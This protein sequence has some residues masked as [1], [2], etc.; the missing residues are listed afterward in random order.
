MNIAIAI[1]RY[2]PLASGIERS[3]E[4]MARD[5]ISRGHRVTVI[6]G[7]APPDMTLDGGEILC[8]H[9]VDFRH[10]I[11]VAR[12]ARW[13]PQ[14]LA[15][16]QA[17]ITLSM[18]LACPAILVQ[19]R[20]GILAERLKREAVAM[21]FASPKSKRAPMHWLNLPRQAGLRRERATAANPM[22]RRFIAISEYVKQQLIHHHQIAPDRIDLIP[23]ASLLQVPS[24]Q[25]R[26]ASRQ[27][28]RAAFNI[29][30]QADVVLFL[31]QHSSHL[32]GIDPLLKATR[33]LIDQGKIITLILAGH[34]PYRDQLAIAKLNLR[35]HIRM[36]GPTNEI[37]TLLS[38]ADLSAMPSFFD[39]SS[40]IVME[41]LMMGVPVVTSRFNG[42]GE[43][44]LTDIGRQS[45]QCIDDPTDI[46]MLADAILSGLD[47]ANRERCREHA[48]HWQSTLAMTRHVDALELL[49]SQAVGQ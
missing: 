17:E 38:A 33:R 31:A 49:M 5:L 44:L 40:K 29:D 36:V 45:G 37:A 48:G 6:T 19:P 47:P 28:V 2:D 39:P 30:A 7:E 25:K 15:Q 8:G 34:I 24:E 9:T 16:Q 43:F 20:A 14:A 4:Q 22:V 26:A 35:E 12:F 3:T 10:R 46:P 23:N 41:S 1:E 18:T 32:K 13:A 21:N 11:S 27:T 42:A